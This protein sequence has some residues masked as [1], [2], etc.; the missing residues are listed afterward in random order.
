VIKLLFYSLSLKYLFYAVF[1]D[2]K[3]YFYITGE[4]D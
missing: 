3:V 1:G 2:T 4:K